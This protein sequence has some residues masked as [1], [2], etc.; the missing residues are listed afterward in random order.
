MGKVSLRVGGVAVWCLLGAAC[1]ARV[2]TESEGTAGAAGSAATGSEPLCGV[3]NTERIADFVCGVTTAWCER[4]AGCC[5]V[6]GFASTAGDCRAQQGPVCVERVRANLAAGACFDVAAYDP[7]CDELTLE[8]I[9]RCSTASLLSVDLLQRS[10]ALGCSNFW[11]HGHVP[12]GDFCTPGGSAQ[13]AQA[14]GERSFCFPDFSNGT[15]ENACNVLHSRAPGESC[16]I[17]DSCL[18]GSRCNSAGV[19][20]IPG[21]TG[22]PCASDLSDCRS[23]L[24]RDGACVELSGARCA[25][26]FS[27]GSSGDCGGDGLCHERPI[28]NETLCDFSVTTS[29]VLQ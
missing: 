7:A 4:L 17:G 1:L 26:D 29:A 18:N 15:S 25:G 16:G 28:A 21:D 20:A 22:A 6:A 5:Q 24:C 9:S 3:E 12:E 2:E 13:C 27:C 11:I 10:E 14:D 19:C 8:S 23:G